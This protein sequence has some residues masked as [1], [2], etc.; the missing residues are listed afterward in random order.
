[1]QAYLSKPAFHDQIF[2]R[3]FKCFISFMHFLDNFFTGIACW[4]DLG[5]AQNC[6]VQNMLNTLQ[7]K[8]EKRPAS[9]RARLGVIKEITIFSGR[10]QRPSPSSLSALA[11]A[12]PAVSQILSS[13]PRK[14]LCPLVW[15][16]LLG[17]SML[18]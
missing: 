6:G 14:H 8:Q 13:Q 5:K 12:V 15:F 17:T 3:T 9:Y 16:I 7:T 10:Q 11:R 1:M 18:A 4:T 2:Q